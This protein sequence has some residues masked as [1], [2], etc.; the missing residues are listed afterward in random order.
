MSGAFSLACRLLSGQEVEN[1]LS[2]WGE[3]PMTAK[4]KMASQSRK[5]ELPIWREPRGVWLMCVAS[6]G[7]DERCQKSIDFDACD[8]Y[9]GC[10]IE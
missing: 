8:L 9:N 5:Q 3:L 10:C 6:G 4:T 2:I 7:V 1:S